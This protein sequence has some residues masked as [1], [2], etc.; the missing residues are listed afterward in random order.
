MDIE[1][2]GAAK[3]FTKKKTEAI[4][5]AYT[6]KGDIFEAI[7]LKNYSRYFT[8]ESYAGMSCDVGSSTFSYGAYLGNLA[9]YDSY[10]FYAP[11]NCQLYVGSTPAY[12]ALTVLQKP[13]GTWETGAAYRYMVSADLTHA[14]RYRKSESNLPTVD[15]PMSFNSGTLFVI[16]VTAG[17]DANIYVKWPH[18]SDILS[19]KMKLNDTQIAQ[20]KNRFFVSTDA[21]HLY[22]YLPTLVNDKY[23]KYPILHYTSVPN[24]ADGWGINEAY[25]ATY[26]NGVFTDRTKVCLVGEWEMAIKLTGRSDFIG[27][28][29][30]GDEVNTYAKFYVDGIGYT[31]VAGDS[32]ACSELKIVQKSTMYDPNDHTTVVGYHTKEHVFTASGIRIKQ[33]IDW[34]VTDTADSS[35]I[36][37]LPIIRGNDTT[38]IA[39]ITE[40]AFDELTYDEYDVSVGGFSNY[41]SQHISGRAALNIYGTTS[42]ISARISADIVNRPASAFGFVQNIVND[43]NKLYLAYCGDGFAITV[44]DKWEWES[45]YKLMCSK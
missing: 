37:M 4:S 44:G 32:F 12:Y 13:S 11:E 10:A 29:A 1:T 27:T 30:H 28:K 3:K 18:Y 15:S 38:S 16:T 24:N 20:S 23:I 40:K 9:G 26:S 22:A 35:Y 2:L 7:S 6:D 34:V 31:L 41:I 25:L 17:A 19:P 45:A 21:T 33:R 39:Q 36:A 43:Y 14:V 5:I 8:S 42:G